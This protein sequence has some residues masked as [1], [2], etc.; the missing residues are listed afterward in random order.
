MVDDILPA[1][2]PTQLLPQHEQEMKDNKM[3]ANTVGH[4]Q[5]T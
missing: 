3:I 1:F 2:P 5:H 4:A